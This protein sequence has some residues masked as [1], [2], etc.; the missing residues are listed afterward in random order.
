MRTRIK[1][2]IF[3]LSINLLFLIFAPSTPATAAEEDIEPSVPACGILDTS[4]ALTYAVNIGP[5]ISTASFALNWR[6][7]ASKINMGLQTPGGEWI[8]CERDSFVTCKES[9][10]SKTY[11]IERPVTGRWIIKVGPGNNQTVHED[12]C[13]YAHLV[14]VKSP[15]QYAA[16]FSGLF[17]DYST[18]EDLDGIDDHITI[19]ASVAIK[20]AGDYSATGIINNMQNGEKIEINNAA[21]LNLGAHNIRFDLYDLKSPGPYRLE[22]LS[23]YDENGNKMDTYT[24][25]YTTKKYNIGIEQNLSAKL[26]GNYSDYGSDLNGDGLYEYLTVDVGVMVY[27][28]GNYSVMGYLYD[29]DDKNVVWSLGS[30]MLPIGP[31]IMHMDFDGKTIERHKFNGTYRLKELELIRGDSDVENLS[32]EDIVMNA[33]VTHPYD[34]RE[35]VDPVWPEKSLSGDGKGEIL[36]TILVKSILPVFKDRYSMDIVGANMPP[37]SSNWTVIG[38]KNGYSYDLP[39]IHMPSKP[40][41]FTVVASNVKNLNVGVKKDP[42]EGGSNFTRTWISTRATADKN[43]TARIDNDMISPGRYQFKIFGEAIDNTTQVTLEM[44]VI[45]KL[46]IN[47]RFNL[48]LNTSGFPTSNYSINVKAIN[49]SVRFDEINLD[50]PS[51]GF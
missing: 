9:N 29:G 40:N 25:K 44:K 22:R 10:T 51:N 12:Y 38:S 33:T 3:F 15:D 5:D 4:E 14:N 39:G 8:Q 11:L 50:G 21:F 32:M 35:F 24:K 16:R 48:A 23:L 47:G 42:V 34:Y 31:N 46:L 27:D 26:T 30:A 19:E 45:K 17:S 2:S 20:V 28:P 1:F 41:N 49:D 43:G 37:I 7:D 6:N 13:I 18:D 36:L